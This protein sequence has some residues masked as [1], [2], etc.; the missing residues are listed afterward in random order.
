[1][2]VPFRVE[3]A[4]LGRCYGEATPAARE[5]V[6]VAAR[7]AL[8]LEATYTGKAMAQLL[9]DAGSGRLDGKRVLFIDTYSSV[10][11]HPLLATLDERAMPAAIRAIL[12]R[13][14]D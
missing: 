6:R 8:E 9:A 13:R 2:P 11:L 5:A 7:A 1:L 10:D 12:A 4:Q 14:D 3:H